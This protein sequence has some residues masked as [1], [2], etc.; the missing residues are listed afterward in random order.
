MTL[1]PGFV[2]A[3]IIPPDILE[4]EARAAAAVAAPVVTAPTEG[5]ASH[6]ASV[7]LFEDLSGAVGGDEV[8]GGAVGGE[9]VVVGSEEMEVDPDWDMM[10]DADDD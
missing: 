6:D 10:D 1:A 8:V 3:P 4:A 5:S 7:D 2:P 9:E